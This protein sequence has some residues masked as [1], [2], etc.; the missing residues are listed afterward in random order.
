MLFDSLCFDF[1]G[2]EAL[3]PRLL[4]FPSS[5]EFWQAYLHYSFALALV[6]LLGSYELSLELNDPLRLWRSSLS[7]SFF[8]LIYFFS[9]GDS[10]HMRL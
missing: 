10:W 9:C 5:L 2:T 6:L 4:F 3:Q 1:L 7:L 8:D